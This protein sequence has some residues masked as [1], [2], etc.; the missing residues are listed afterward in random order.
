MVQFSREQKEQSDKTKDIR[1]EPRPRK[2]RRVRRWRSSLSRKILMINVLVLLIPVFGLLHLE[3]YRLSL[4]VSELEAM[5][6]QGRAFS[7][8]I[9]STAVVAGR[10][11]DE[12]LVPELTRSLMRGMLRDVGV[13]A[14]I[15]S[16]NGQLLGDSLHLTGAGQPVTM[17]PLPEAGFWSGFDH[18]VALVGDFLNWLPG[19]EEDWELYQ[20]A[21]VQDARHYSEV[22]SALR[23]RPTGIV[24][25]DAAGRLVLSAAVPIRR[26]RQVL[27]ALMLSKDGQE[28]TRQVQDRRRDILIVCGL[29]LAVTIFLSLYLAWT[30]GQP[31]RRLADAADRV[32]F[33]K[34][35]AGE[36]P[37]FSGRSDE[38][39]D[40]S[41]A[42]RDMTEA[43][44]A[45]VH[46][47]EGFAADVSHE[48][49]NPLTSLRSAVETVTRVS[50]PDQQKRLMNI[51]LDDV[52]RL[53]RLISD[54]SDASRLDAELSRTLMEPLDLNSLLKTF[55]ELQQITAERRNVSCRM[56]INEEQDLCVSGMESRLG[57]VLG[58][59]LSN[60]ESFAPEGSTIL[61][62]A[63]EEEGSAVITVEDEGPGIPEK[64][65]GDIFNRFYTERPEAEKFGTH[66]GLG[67]SI[68][69]QIVEVH[70]GTIHAEN[71][72]DE[73]GEILGARFVIRLPVYQPP[74]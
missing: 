26:Y 52:E 25:Q 29:A 58:N 33:S 71:R 1:V 39:G 35:K 43:L 65:L 66:S 38:I 14:R 55:I 24:R 46:A 7:L 13:R 68:S 44:W 61:L 74:L 18:F 67:L 27:G 8:S 32:R 45:R 34:G 54:I 9:G 69:K 63:Y 5:G 49:K 72:K 22:V 40:L 73:K 12:R 16:P 70:G 36:I 2:V 41:G 20:E 19:G 47:I 57:Q 3:Q 59:L 37:D 6:T 15:F 11:G 62:K 48:L 60:A 23:G 50:N 30:I 28:I 42:L 31:L 56:E 51:I 4:I 10:V 53:D 17:T 21:R 64:N